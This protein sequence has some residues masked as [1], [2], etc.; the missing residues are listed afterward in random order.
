MRPLFERPKKATTIT[1][2][3]L[4]WLSMCNSRLLPKVVNDEGVRKRWVGI[5]WVAEGPA[6]GREVKVVH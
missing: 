5:G 4:A 6:T 1:V 3:R 2:E